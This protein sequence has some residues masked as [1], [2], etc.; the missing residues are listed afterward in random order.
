MNERTLFLKP[1]DPVEIRNTINDM[2]IK[3]GGVDMI[4]TKTL[5]ILANYITHPLSHIINMCFEQAIWPDAL[6]MADIIPI[7]KSGVENKVSNYRPISL[8]SNIAKIFEKIVHNRILNFINGNNIIS[9]QQY[10]FVRGKGTTNALQYLTNILYNKL[11]KS[12]P[13]LITFLDE[14]E[15]RTI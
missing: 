5:K 11:D 3:G 7:H 12:K 15:N 1:T 14:E 13:A 6:K 9:K 8:I 4:N 10:R 2:K